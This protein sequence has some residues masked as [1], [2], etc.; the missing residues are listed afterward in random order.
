M[1]HVE[2][3]GATGDICSYFKIGG[4]V[5]VISLFLTAHPAGSMSQI[6]QYCEYI[7]PA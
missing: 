6:M 3:H 7:C 5:A 4:A 2:R 1:F